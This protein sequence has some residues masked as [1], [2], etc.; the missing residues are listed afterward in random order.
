MTAQWSERRWQCPDLQILMSN[1]SLQSA[2]PLA[3]S[4]YSGPWIHPGNGCRWNPDGPSC[5]TAPV[6]CLVL[7]LPAQLL[8][9][10]WWRHDLQSQESNHTLQSDMPLA[11]SIHRGP[12]AAQPLGAGKAQMDTSILLLLIP[13]SQLY[14]PAWSLERRW[15]QPDI[16]SQDSSTLLDCD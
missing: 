3:A 9:R 4:L 12:R 6:P 8:E 7:Y 1:H 13:A 15:Q 5:S 14:P 2:T 16:Q 10:K 11:G